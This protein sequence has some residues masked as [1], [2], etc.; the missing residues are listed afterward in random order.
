VVKGLDIVGVDFREIIEFHHVI[1]DGFYFRKD[2]YRPM[3][4][5]CNPPLLSSSSWLPPSTM[6][7]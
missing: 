4:R 1:S 6:A 7:I 2:P 3:G 5:V